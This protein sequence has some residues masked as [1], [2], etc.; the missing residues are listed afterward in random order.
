MQCR[1]CD[2]HLIDKARFCDDC[3][4]ATAA[5]DLDSDG[6]LS[7][8]GRCC[9]LLRGN[10]KFCIYCGEPSPHSDKYKGRRQA[11]WIEEV[12]LDP[13][14]QMAIVGILLIVAGLPA[15]S[16]IRYKTTSQIPFVTVVWEEEEK[17]Q[18][19]TR[20]AVIPRQDRFTI[21]PLI[22]LGEDR[23]DG[24]NI[25]MAGGV[26]RDSRGNLYVSD[27][28]GHRVYRI[29]PTGERT[30][31]AG[32]GSAGFSGDGGIATSAEIDT[33][34][35]LA[36]DELDRI[37]IADTGNNR[38]RLVNESGIIKT[39]AGADGD[40]GKSVAIAR[41]SEADKATLLSPVSVTVDELGALYVA[42]SSC[43]I[44]VRKPTVWVLKQRM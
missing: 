33:P 19:G 30:V 35:G 16:P 39:I 4:L 11:G 5:L 3:G 27:A 1:S 9:G 15:V 25:S 37:Y 24:M 6:L 42:E 36:I 22:A 26:A 8:C 12:L 21:E 44:G 43:K 7:Y 38:I 10:K 34:T 29:A 18:V 28:A 40:P 14:V 2:H 41:F 13:R 17:E 31:I 23:E 32:N 20:R